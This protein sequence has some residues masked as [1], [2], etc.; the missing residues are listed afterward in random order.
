L[1]QNLLLTTKCHVFIC[2][3][4]SSLSHYAEDMFRELFEEAT[5]I[6]ERTCNLNNKVDMLKDSVQQFD[7]NQVV[8]TLNAI[9]YYNQPISVSFSFS[10]NSYCMGILYCNF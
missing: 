2:R 1:A 3:Q 10:T 9:G 8:G 6:Y 5:S 4:L 7:P